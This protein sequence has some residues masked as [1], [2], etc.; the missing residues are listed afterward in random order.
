[1]KNLKYIA[2]VGSIVLLAGNSLA[3]SEVFSTSFDD[4]NSKKII[5]RTEAV[6]AAGEGCN[7]SNALKIT[8]TDKKQYSVSG[9][10][11]GKLEAGEY[12]CSMKLRAE[13]IKNNN[14]TPSN[15]V[16]VIAIEHYNGKKYLSQNS[17]FFKVPRKGQWNNVE[18]QF[19]VPGQAT[20]S[21][22]S[23]FLR[24]GMTGTVWI[25]DIKI[26]RN[27][28][29]TA[30]TEKSDI[31]TA[32]ITPETAA[33][34]PA[35]NSRKLIYTTSFEPSEGKKY[36]LRSEAEL[37]KE[38]FNGTMALKIHRSDKNQYTV[39][40][41][42]LGKLEAGYYTLNMKLRSENIRNSRGSKATSVQVMAIEHYA[43][44]RYHSQNSQF[45]RVSKPGEWND[46]KFSFNVP[47][48][49]TRS[50]LSFFIRK[51]MTGTVWIDDVTLVKSEGEIPAVNLLQPE[52]L[53]I[54]GSTAKIVFKGTQGSPA[55]T[56]ALI[57]LG[58]QSK[59][60]EI[61]SN[62]FFRTEFTNLTTGTMQ[63]E[64][65]ILDLKKRTFKLK[66]TFN[67]F[68]KAPEK[69]PD[70]AVTFDKNKNLLVNGK[71]YMI[72][73]L[74]SLSKH[75]KEV[76]E[77]GFNTIIDYTLFGDK[78]EK[79]DRIAHIRR[80]MNDLHKYN[81]KALVSVQ[82]QFPGRPSAPTGFDNVSGV[83]ECVTAVAQGI[84][85]HPALLGWYVS[86]EMPR[87]GLPMVQKI[88]EAVSI[89]D[90]W[91]PTYTL[92]CR[93]EDMPFYANTGDVIGMDPYP[94]IS[95][96][97]R[98]SIRAVADQTDLCVKTNQPVWMTHQGFSWAVYDG[99]PFE[100]YDQ[101]RKITAD[102]I[103]AMP[104]LAAIHGAKGF[105]FFS[106]DGAISRVAKHSQADADANWAALTRAAKIL[107]GLSPFIT[108]GIAKD[109]KFEANQAGTF[110]GKIFEDGKG[111]VRVVL[112]GMHNKAV[113]RF[114]LPGYPVLKSMNKL[115]QYKKNG[116][117]EINVDGVQFDI[118][119]N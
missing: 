59:I 34:F 10:N 100:K 20:R 36:Q 60:I 3:A 75:A 2:Y 109:I 78:G 43:G 57:T 80:R 9:V 93:V 106:Y 72:V 31:Q 76:A 94:I 90:P 107:N 51:G 114:K 112:V 99:T 116:L 79:F 12:T 30:T 22:V 46:I 23:I 98:H 77:A 38:G 33:S 65:K 117:Y 83:Y 64:I 101:S 25:D 71:P 56:K 49:I 6:L 113:A 27:N 52:R 50:S 69:A 111:N 28:S 58:S 37:V 73:G 67:V 63:L 8:R 5:L 74:Y 85:D 62:G 118:L 119:S 7:N 53:T 26:I 24:K 84:K 41:C 66:E 105:I 55:G 108:S 54:F 88:R 103:A 44:K 110:R 39:S 102:E 48:G 89:A 68:V 115:T 17:A 92:T 42:S 18:F 47:S 40:G 96:P 81:I 104:L 70:Y 86:D 61:D 35:D 19:K 29:K 15:N 45:C 16:Q 32:E 13:N 1:M 4:S 14:N 97:G 82:H 95:R 11:L 87:D 21:G 91:H